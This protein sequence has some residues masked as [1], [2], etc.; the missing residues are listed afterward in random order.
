LGGADAAK[1]RRWG[2]PSFLTK[3]SQ[4]V[5]I[6]LALLV[7]AKAALGLFVLGSGFSHVSDDDYARVVIAQRF[8]HAPLLD[9]SGTS[10]LP[11]PF[12]VTGGAMLL[13]GR[14]LETARGVAFVLG[15]L[16]VVPPY[17]ALRAAFVARAPALVGVVLA[18]CVPWNAW[19]AVATVPEALTASLVAA[20]AI[21]VF[22]ERWRPLAAAGL[23]AASLSR[24]EAWPVCAIFAIA[25]AWSAR[26]RAHRARNVIAAAIALAGPLAWMAW[27]A[28]AHG[29][30]THFLARVSAFR[31]ATGAA[32]IPL[33]AKWLGY[34]R[35]LADCAPDVAGLAAIGL[36]GLRDR[37]ARARW[38]L[39]LLMGAALFAFLVYGDLHDGAPTHHPERALMP[40][41]WLLA[42]FGVDGTRAFARRIAWGRTKREIWIVGAITAATIAWVASR[43]DAWRAFPG[44]DSA[45]DRTAQLDRGRA[46]RAEGARAIV[47]TPCAYE[48]FALLAAFGAPERA[49]IEPRELATND[50]AIP[51]CPRVVRR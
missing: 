9:P 19:L 44:R 35:A 24:Y 13:F 2:A 16:S 49:E 12:W 47:V 7:V 38:T 45:S 31:Q 29:S 28:H 14:S 20:G 37:V 5:A 43:P 41:V 18:A 27:N 11:F 4:T 33:E 25:C 46:L 10:W 3:T 50:A 23:L 22:A 40:L 48:H 26:H 39:P 42:A 8:A 6:D 17:L 30:A 51:S 36:L 1:R 34:P 32:N 15:A 21:A